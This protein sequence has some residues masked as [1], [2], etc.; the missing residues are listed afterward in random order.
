SVPI[1]RGLIQAIPTALPPQPIGEARKASNLHRIPLGVQ[2]RSHFTYFI[3]ACGMG[4][5]TSVL[6]MER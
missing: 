1:N 4:W 3:F 5:Q 2:G 6:A